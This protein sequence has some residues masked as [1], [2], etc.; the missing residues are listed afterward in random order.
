MVSR[1]GVAQKPVCPGLKAAVRS[2]RRDWLDE[3]KG[4]ERGSPLLESHSTLSSMEVQPSEV[5][6]QRTL[7]TGL[8]SPW[9]HLPTQWRDTSRVRESREVTSAAS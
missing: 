5:G 1:E 7:V 3:N 9:S 2:E 6:L 4:P 8:W